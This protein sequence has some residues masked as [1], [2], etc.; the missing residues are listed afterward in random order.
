MLLDT[1][2]YSYLINGDERV[3]MA[4]E[5]A[6]I[7]YFSVFV[8]AELLFGF[9]NGSRETRNIE[10]LNRFLNKPSVYALHTSE[11]TA[12]HYARINLNLKQQ[13]TPIPTNDIWIAAHCVEVN[14]TL[15]TFDRHFDQIPDLNVYK[16]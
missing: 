11:K 15:L 6:T 5:K 8:M 4:L 7:V 9:K 2:A 16:F 1:N 10:I 13:G 3:A 14:A 12:Q